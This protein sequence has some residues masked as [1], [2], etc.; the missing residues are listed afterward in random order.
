M[1]HTNLKC[2]LSRTYKLLQ[3]NNINNKAKLVIATKKLN[4]QRISIYLK[5][6]PN[7]HTTIWCV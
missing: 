1:K 2:D 3:K 4:I 7:N 6:Q 5:Q